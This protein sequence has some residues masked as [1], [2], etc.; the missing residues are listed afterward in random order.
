MY[1][2]YN[3]LY[4]IVRARLVKIVEI[5]PTGYGHVR[6]MGIGAQLPYIYVYI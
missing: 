6:F 1:Y 3:N 4:I 5:N 2:Y